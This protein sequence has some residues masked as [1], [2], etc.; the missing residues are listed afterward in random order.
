MFLNLKSFPHEMMIRLVIVLSIML[1]VQ[2]KDCKI[3]EQYTIEGSK[4][5]DVKCRVL[6]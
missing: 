5:S 6:K 1:E 3:A 2:E 4:K